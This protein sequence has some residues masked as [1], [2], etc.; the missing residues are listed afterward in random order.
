M[1]LEAAE[2]FKKTRRTKLRRK[3]QHAQLVLTN[4]LLKNNSF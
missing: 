3:S 4:V 2:D 1:P